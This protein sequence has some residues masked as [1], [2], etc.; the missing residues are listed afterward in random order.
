MTTD[1]GQWNY[2][3]WR[4]QVDSA[5]TAL[6]NICKQEPGLQTMQ[7][8]ERDE[9]IFAFMVDALVRFGSHDCILCD[10]YE[11]IRWELDRREA[12]RLGC[13]YFVKRLYLEKKT[14]AA[15]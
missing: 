4:E 9:Q 6:W 10:P 12:E 2:E 8:E 14:E 1:I 11:V 5:V 13:K 7:C 15:T 3:Q